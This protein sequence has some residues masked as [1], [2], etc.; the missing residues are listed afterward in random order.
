MKTH[1]GYLGGTDGAQCTQCEGWIS[2]SEDCALLEP[3]T[4]EENGSVRVEA[5]AIHGVLCMEC[6]TSL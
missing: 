1:Q 5:T 3:A 4:V 2:E 6:Y